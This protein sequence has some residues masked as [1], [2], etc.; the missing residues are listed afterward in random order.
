MAI[1]R[2]VFIGEKICLKVLVW[3]YVRCVILHNFQILSDSC[4]TMKMGHTFVNR[5]EAI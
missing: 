3:L 1:S 5:R 4:Y 2:N